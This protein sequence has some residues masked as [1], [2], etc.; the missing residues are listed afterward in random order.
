MVSPRSRRAR[1]RACSRPSSE[2][3]TSVAPAKRSSAVSTVAPC[4]TRKR[5]VLIGQQF[6]V[7]F[8][9]FA[10]R[11]S[12]P[13]GGTLPLHVPRI[14]TRGQD[15]DVRKHVPPRIEMLH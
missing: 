13:L 2:S 4:L 11:A 5:R 12:H 1:R 6:E 8:S 14:A 7:N 10:L 3:W 9:L 15:G